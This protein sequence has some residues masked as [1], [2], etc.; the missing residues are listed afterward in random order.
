LINF[1]VFDKVFF[2]CCNV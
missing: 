2:A 1:L